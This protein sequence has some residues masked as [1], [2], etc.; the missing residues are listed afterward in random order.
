DVAVA[1]KGRLALGW[2]G[3]DVGSG[4]AERVHAAPGC[5]VFEL[6]D[7][8]ARPLGPLRDQ[9]AAERVQPFLGFQDVAIT[10]VGRVTVA[11]HG[12]LPFD[13]VFLFFYY[14]RAIRAWQETPEIHWRS[15]PGLN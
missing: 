5:R 7:E 3:V 11:I 12:Q 15:E 13:A 10:F 14:R 1:G 9:H 4:E 2:N 8:K 6:V